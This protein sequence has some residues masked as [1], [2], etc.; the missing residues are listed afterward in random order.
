LEKVRILTYHRIGISRTGRTERLTVPPGRFARQIGLLRG[1]RTQFADLDQCGEWLAGRKSV[2]KPLVLSFDDGYAD[3]CQYAL[4]LLVEHGISAIVY[5]VADRRQDNWMNLGGG[6][7]LPLMDWSQ[8]RDLARNGIMFGSH[9]QTH[10]DLTQ[11]SDEQLHSELVDSKKEI[12]DQLGQPVNHFCYPFGA[13]DDRVVDAV[14]EAGYTTATTTRRGAV[15]PGCDPLRLPR[16]SVGKNMRLPR[17]L[18][19]ITW[20]H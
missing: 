17:F 20:R 10:P 11:L 16:L 15:V 9:T 13:H 5:L 7:A 14:G 8:V 2:G 6:A 1:L 12:E 19:R 4:P 18:S 3:I